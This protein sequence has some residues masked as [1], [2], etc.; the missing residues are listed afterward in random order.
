MRIYLICHHPPFLLQSDFARVVCVANLTENNMKFSIFK[1]LTASAILFFGCQ[2]GLMA[3]DNASSQKADEQPAAQNTAKAPAAQ[4]TAK[5][6]TATIPQRPAMRGYYPHRPYYRPWRRRGSGSGFG[7]GSG[8]GPSF[9]SRRGPGWDDWGRDPFFDD[10]F[11]NDPFM[12]R[13]PWRRR[14]SG[15]GFGF[16]SDDGPS[17]GSGPSFGSDRGPGFGPWNDRG[18]RY[19][20]RGPSFHGPWDRGSGS[21]MGF[22]L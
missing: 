7:F 20:D 13:D 1:I 2:T 22:G 16:G 14:G 4:S 18:R 15:S 21:G 11:M 6:P 5:A 10:P 12:D 9:G 19:H 17:W 8:S 3:E